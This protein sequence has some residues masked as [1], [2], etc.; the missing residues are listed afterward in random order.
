MVWVPF[1]FGLWSLILGQD[2]SSDLANYHLYNGYAFLH[3][4]TEVDFGVASIQTYFNPILDVF[5]YFLNT[6]LYPPLFGFLIG[7]IHGLNYTLVYKIGQVLVGAKL[8][9]QA[10]RLIFLLS[11]AGVLTSNFLSVIGTS[12]GDNISALL[13]LLS[14]L[15][16]INKWGELQSPSNVRIFSLILA[17]IFVGTATTLKL[18]NASYALSLCLSLIFI[19]IPYIKRLKLIF[20]YGFGALIGFLIFGGFWYFKIWN[21]FHNPF[22]PIFNNIF[23]INPDGNSTIFHWG[24]NTIWEVLLWPFIITIDTERM[25]GG[26]IHQIIWPV[27]YILAITCIYK[28]RFKKNS[29]IKLNSLDIYVTSFIFIGFVVWMKAFCVQRYLIPLELIAPCLIFILCLN[30]FKNKE[31]FK[32][33][34]ISNIILVLLGGYGNYGHTEWQNPP[35]KIDLPYIKDPSNS[36]V[37]I[38]NNEVGWLVTLFPK[39]LSFVRLD[40]FEK[41]YNKYA[42][43]ILNK[44]S[45]QKFY[46]FNGYYYWRNDNVKKWSN[47][48]SS[49]GIMSTKNSCKKLDLFIKYI[50]FKGQVNFLEEG[51]YSCEISI[52]DQDKKDF[53]IEN[54]K[55]IFEA[56]KNLNKYGFD[57]EK[58]SCAIIQGKFGNETRV[59]NWCKITSQ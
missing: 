33:I 9:K 13:I 15:L 37:I 56:E 47:S 3:G 53:S 5:Y 23:Q 30:L 57:L 24:P 22:F 16:V 39:E 34:I 10:D 18:T 19:P 41:K 52:R 46:L 42:Y 58:N 29:S 12:S 43:N 44:K 51:K 2:R 31:F 25:A 38:I 32:I 59:F 17:G 14:L 48:L 36:S 54:N 20:I 6:H 11:I 26:K 1:F 55:I 8:K 28:N 21:L 7:F 35:F 45:G 40:A 50:K 4:K 49:L 27:L